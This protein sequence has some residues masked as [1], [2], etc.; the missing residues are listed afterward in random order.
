MRRTLLGSPALALAAGQP[1]VFDVREFGLQADRKQTQTAAFQAA[2][3][4]C[5]RS[6][7]GTVYVP[8]GQYVAAGILLKSRVSLYLE[9]GASILASQRRED[10]AGARFL[11]G[12]RKAER[13]AVLGNGILH[14]QATGDLRRR[15]GPVDPMPEFRPMIIRIEDSTDVSLRDFSILY[16]D[17]WAC[18]LNRCRRVHVDG[19]TIFNNFYRTNSDGIDPDSCQDVHIANCHITAGD[20]CICLKTNSGVPCTDVTVTNCTLETIATAIKLGTASD[21]DFRNIAISNCT[22]RN[23]TVGVGF[24]V[25]DGGT[26]EGVTVSNLAIETL[27]EPDKAVEWLR[28]MIYPVFV[29]IEKRTPESR[30]GVVRDLLFNGLSIRSDNGILLQGMPE[31]LIE[32]VTLR[33][34]QFRVSRGFDYSGR[35]KHLGGV[36]NR[37]D[38]RRSIFAQQPSYCTL[39]NIRDVVVDNLR[40]D[41]APAVLQAQPRTAFAAVN[42]SGLILRSIHRNAA[43]GAGPVIELKNCRAASVMNCTAPAGTEAFLRL[44]ATPENEVVLAANDLG[45]AKQPIERK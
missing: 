44:T 38:E 8:P 7:G 31:S 5:H 20:D 35:R 42:A 18:H 32:N 12:A 43:E 26:I 40:V 36:S 30:V 17:S 3:D 27:R 15:P 39:A 22:I 41:I 21:A 37:N 4:A 16:S 33:D 9:N 2:I 19:V 1:G 23:S 14:G 10:Y 45:R 34:V 6:G 28:N 13:I 29:D 11:V 25:K 24:F